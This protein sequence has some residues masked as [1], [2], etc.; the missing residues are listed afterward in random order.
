VKFGMRRAGIIGSDEVRSP[1]CEMT[2][3]NE[4]TLISVLATFKK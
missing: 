3:A 4:Q 1:L 2:K